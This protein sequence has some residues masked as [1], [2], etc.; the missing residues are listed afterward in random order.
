MLVNRERSC[1]L[2]IDIQERLH[3]VMS[4]TDEVTQNTAMLLQAAKELEVPVL[5]SE[6]YPH[7]LG[8][9][10]EALQEHL[11]GDVVEKVTFSCAAEPTYMDAF[12]ALKRPQAIICGIEAHICVTQTALDLVERGVEVFVVSDATGSR[13]PD[14][15]RVAL[16]RMMQAGCQVLPTE[17]VL[18]EW[19][20]VAGTH[21][22]KTISKLVK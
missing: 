5:T 19:L 9:T 11:S 21:E 16:D 10:V 14:N 20:R 13:K 8:G 7:G 6:Q 22:F 15:H 3:P 1:L 12:D 17:S 4:N 2:V 18:F